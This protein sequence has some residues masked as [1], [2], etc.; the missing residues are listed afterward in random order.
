M[1]LIDDDEIE[2]GATDD[3]D[4]VAG[5]RLDEAADQAFA[6]QQTTA[7]RGLGGVEHRLLQ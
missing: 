1:F 7:E 6:V 4:R 5:G 2:A 3:L